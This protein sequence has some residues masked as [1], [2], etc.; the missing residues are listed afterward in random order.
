MPKHTREQHHVTG[1]PT[2]PVSQW[3]HR[4]VPSFTVTHIRHET[5]TGSET[6]QLIA[7]QPDYQTFNQLDT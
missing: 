6:S 2:V 3:D 7:E 5:V 1:A 4:N